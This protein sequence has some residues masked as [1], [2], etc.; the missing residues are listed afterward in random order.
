VWDAGKRWRSTTRASLRLNRDNG[1][2]YLDYDRY[3]AFHQ[4]RFRRDPWMLLAEVRLYYYH[5]LHQT[6]SETDLDKRDRTELSFRARA[7][8]KLYKG[9]HAYA[10]YLRERVRSNLNLEE[11]DVETVMAGL[12]WDF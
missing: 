12:F 2:G 4:G 10:E 8:R 11:Y 7:E 3:Q 1:G 9:L 6:V 5:Y